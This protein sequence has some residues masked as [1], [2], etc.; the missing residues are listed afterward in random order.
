MALN[1]L[2]MRSCISEFNDQ[3]RSGDWLSWIIRLRNVRGEQQVS[4]IDYA[5]WESV[6]RR[7]RVKD[8]DNIIRIHSVHPRIMKLHYELYV[9]LMHKPSPLSRIEREWVAVVVSNMN[10]C[11][12]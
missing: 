4:F 3:S 7:D 10:K 9:E 12:Y 2:S 6:P 1:S 11:H 5:S 8:E